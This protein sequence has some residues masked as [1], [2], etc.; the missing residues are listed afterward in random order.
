[1]IA[2]WDEFGIKDVERKALGNGG[3]AFSLHKIKD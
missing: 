3:R 2:K 1:M